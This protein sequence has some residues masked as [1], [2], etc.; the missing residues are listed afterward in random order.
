MQY[1]LCSGLSM[2]SLCWSIVGK[3]LFYFF[4]ISRLINRQKAC[5]T[6]PFHFEWDGTQHTNNMKTPKY[7]SALLVAACTYLVSCTFLS[8]CTLLASSPISH[9]ERYL[10]STPQPDTKKYQCTH[11]RHHHEESRPAMVEVYYQ[12]D[13][14][15]SC[16]GLNCTCKRYEEAN[17]ICATPHCI[18]GH[19]LESHYIPNR[20]RW[21][22]CPD[23]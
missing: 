6:S 21:C 1:E 7:I 12:D 9:S 15:I 14:M 11:H 3:T 4:S 2:E 17:C 19:P 22:C 20:N 8:S 5:F 13:G 10:S 23:W 18:C 16:N